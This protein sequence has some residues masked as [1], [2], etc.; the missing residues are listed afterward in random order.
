MGLVCEVFGKDLRVVHADAK[1]T[2]TY[3]HELQQN[4]GAVK[5]PL[6]ALLEK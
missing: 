5:N 2:E 3:T 1:T 6:D 4:L